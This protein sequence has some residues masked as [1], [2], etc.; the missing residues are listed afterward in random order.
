M[1]NQIDRENWMSH[2]NPHVRVLDSYIPASHDS[3]AYPTSDVP[4]MFQNEWVGAVTQLA[5]YTAQLNTGVRYFDMRVVPHGGKLVMHHSSYYYEPFANVLHQINEFAKSHRGE[6]IF[7]DVDTDP[8]Y[9]QQVLQAI[10]ENLDISNFATAHINHD[11]TF[12]TSV[13]WGDFGGKQLLVTFQSN[14][15][16]YRP[17]LLERDKFRS[18]PYDSFNKKSIPQI[19]D[20]LNVQVASWRKDKMFIAQVINTPLASPI[21]NPAEDDA[22]AEGIFNQWIMNHPKGSNLNVIMRDFV[23]AGY[24]RKAIDYIINL[25]EFSSS[26]VVSLGSKIYLEDYIRFKTDGNLYMYLD[27]NN[28]VS[29]TPKK[30]E[31]TVFQVRNRDYNNQSP[32]LLSGNMDADTTDAQ[33]NFRLTAITNNKDNLVLSIND[34]NNQL[35]N[36]ITW[37]ASDDDETF[38]CF[39]PD[40]LNDTSNITDGSKVIIRC[41]QGASGNLFEKITRTIR[42]HIIGWTPFIGKSFEKALQESGGRHLFL[43]TSYDSNGHP[44]LLGVSPG[45]DYATTFII[46]R[47]QSAFIPGQLTTCSAI[48]FN[49]LW[50]V[51]TNL[52]SNQNDVFRTSDRGVNWDGIVGIL[53]DIS[54]VNYDTVWGVNTYLSTTVNNVFRTNDGKTWQAIT[55]YLTNISGVDYNTA[56]GVNTNLSTTGNN[57]FRINDGKTWQA[58]I[59]YLT[60]IS[61]VDYNTAWGV[62]TNIAENSSNVYRTNDGGTTWQNIGGIL[63]NISAVDYNTAWGVNKNGGLYRTKDGGTNWERV[64]LSGF[65]S[66]SAINYELAY[67]ITTDD[68]IALINLNVD[69]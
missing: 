28:K 24:N 65:K 60:N 36:G 26:P 48:D 33:G 29:L 54:A 23:N 1:Q 40:V 62:N 64:E 9:V 21:K 15:T 44:I 11:D 46:E 8:P 42:D 7:L 14:G 4:Q 6:F 17:W 55:G 43:M 58:T 12:N 45:P 41:M 3:S 25:N 32:F 53:T 19:V 57:V 47:A 52:Q 56:W 10:E 69:I 38:T 30:S 31:A 20:Y 51:N 61:A 49:T 67:A 13:T 2:L 68:E 39:N 63:A 50:G 16:V 37:A 5:G 66:V 22:E 34:K 18:S 27:G 59:G 35:F